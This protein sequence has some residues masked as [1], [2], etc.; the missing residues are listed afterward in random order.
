VL[1]VR[2]STGPDGEP[3]VGPPLP[4]FPDVYGAAVGRMSH[5]DYDAFPDGSRF[6]M[7]GSQEDEAASQLMVVL[8]WFEELKRLSPTR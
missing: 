4:L 6:V 5:P 8:N 7:V 2:F 3:S 1:S